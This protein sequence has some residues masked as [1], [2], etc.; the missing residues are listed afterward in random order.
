MPP[1]ILERAAELLAP[2]QSILFI[3]GAGISADSGLPTYRGVG[4][5]YDA[6]DT[7]EGLPIEV[8]LSGEMFRARPEVTWR[9]I[10][11]I[12]QRCRGAQPNVAH[13]LIATLERRLER[14]VVL[15]QNVDGLHAAAGSDK[16]IAIH[17][18]TQ[19]LRCTACS[20]RERVTDYAALDPVL[21][22]C[23]DCAAVIRPDVILF[24]EMLPTDAVDMLYRELDLG[25]DAV[26]SIGTSAVFP[27]ISGPV[28]QARQARR[29][30]IEINPG[31][32]EISPLVDLHL[33]LGASAAM[34][35]IYAALERRWATLPPC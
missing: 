18:D 29:P 17:G 27:Y 11:Q 6:D 15:T 35:G 2:A 28:H 21:P 14:V 19:Q 26:V 31:D 12:E 23:P 30:T 24:G 33:R 34:T 32:T 16:L 22:R 3:T 13:Q 10:R 1:Q 7:E 4:G 20:W 8:C 25:F 5:L 9:Y